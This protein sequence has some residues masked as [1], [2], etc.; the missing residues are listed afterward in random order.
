MLHRPSLLLLAAVTLATACGDGGNQQDGTAPVASDGAAT[1]TVSDM[2]F[3]PEAVEIDAGETV[4]WSF[5]DRMPHDVAFDDGPA[6]PK[7]RTGTW[8]RTFEEP[9]T[10][11][12][13]CTLH[14][15]MTGTVTVR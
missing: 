5:D 9:G 15:N 3:S 12:Y 8:E 13:I 10:Y 6:S 14:P 1:V 11:D 2:R 4:T 7:L